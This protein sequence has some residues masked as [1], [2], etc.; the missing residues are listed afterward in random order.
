M[1]RAA[2]RPTIAP[3]GAPG[4]PAADAEGALSGFASTKREIL[5]TLKREGDVDL[6]TLSKHLGV[7]KMAVYRHVQ[8]LE[9]AGLIERASKRMG[10]G[11]PRL[12]LRLAP[13]ASSI[14]PK[15]YAS[16]TCALLAFI[17]KK[18]G[19]EAVEAALRN[20]TQGVLAEYER[21]VTS[22][23]LGGRVHELQQ[24]RDR[25]GYMAEVRGGAKGRYE[26]FE[27]NC[28]IVA[29]AEQYWEAC[30]VENELF[31]H[32]LRADV[33]TTHRVVA[34]DHVCRFLIKPRRTRDI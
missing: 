18:M 15:A 24:L 5:L 2:A 31:R 10:V 3:S 17:E 21:H 8:E 6:G 7:S 34:G 26:L 25:E 30:K 13:G 27:Y 28:P 33:D 22:D 32:V 29:I 4:A 12:S 1:V 20:R 16:V 14:F 19:R 11:R 23:D 9:E